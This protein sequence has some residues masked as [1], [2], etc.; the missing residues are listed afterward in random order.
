MIP[1]VRKNPKDIIKN[2]VSHVG[3][4]M[5]AMVDLKIEKIR[6]RGKNPSVEAWKEEKNCCEPG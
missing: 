4:N 6:E 1:A 5:H 3:S 2:E